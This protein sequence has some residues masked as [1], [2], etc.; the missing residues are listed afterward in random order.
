MGYFN[1]NK[2]FPAATNNSWIANIKPFIF[3][4]LLSR[5]GRSANDLHPS[6]QAIPL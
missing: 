2:R 5:I 6:A 1:Q 3:F 4:Y